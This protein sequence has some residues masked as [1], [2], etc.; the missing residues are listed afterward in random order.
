M[1]THRWQIADVTKVTTN[2]NSSV[3][4]SVIGYRYSNRVPRS[5]DASSP[6]RSAL[7]NQVMEHPRA[8]RPHET[9]I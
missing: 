1:V 4:A 8:R 2:R 6:T 7:R 5:H 3:S 9:V